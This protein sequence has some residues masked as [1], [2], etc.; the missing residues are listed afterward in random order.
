MPSNINRYIYYIS[1]HLQHRACPTTGLSRG[2]S[3]RPILVYYVFTKAS[4]KVSYFGV[5]F[6]SQEIVFPRYQSSHRKNQ[7]NV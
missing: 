1:R 7:L 2:K 6:D 5:K 3:S 4:T